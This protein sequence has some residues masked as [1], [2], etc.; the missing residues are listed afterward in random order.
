M[1]AAKRRILEMR[2]D[3]FKALAHPIR[4]A[5]V[6][7]LKGGERCVCDIARIEACDRTNISKHLSVLASAGILSSRKEGLKVYYSLKCP[8]ILEF[9]HCIE[10]VIKTDLKEKKRLL[11]RL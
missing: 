6:E 3:V 1:K 7:F 11:S 8:C 2:A 10:N 9:M 4:L 5:V